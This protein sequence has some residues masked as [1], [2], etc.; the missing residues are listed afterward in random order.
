MH[1]KLCDELHFTKS[2]GAWACCGQLHCKHIKRCPSCGSPC[3]ISVV[4]ESEEVPHE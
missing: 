4:I 3:P 2:K 1:C